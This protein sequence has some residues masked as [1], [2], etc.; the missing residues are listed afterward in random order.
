MMAIKEF[1]VE[2]TQTVLVKIDDEKLNDEFNEEFQKGMWKIESIECHAKHLA[3]LEARG[4]IGYNNFVEGYGD[5]KKDLNCSVE[6]VDQD[7]D[8]TLV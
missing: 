7:E 3:Q 1:S 8:C 5:I 4:L 6:I 2:V